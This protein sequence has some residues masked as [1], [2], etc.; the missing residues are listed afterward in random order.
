MC[1]REVS[2]FKK[3]KKG[4][5]GKEER[6]ILIEEKKGKTFISY[7]IQLSKYTGSK[8]SKFGSDSLKRCTASIK[9]YIDLIEY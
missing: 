8:T 3:K 5:R 9:L 7:V 1:R 2:I 4:M 6:G